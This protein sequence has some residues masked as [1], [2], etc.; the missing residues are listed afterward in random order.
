MAFFRD[1]VGFLATQ[2]DATKERGKKAAQTPTLYRSEFTV[3]FE[4]DWR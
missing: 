3:A 4:L 1:Q 2:R